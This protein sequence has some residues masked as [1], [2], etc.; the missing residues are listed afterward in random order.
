MPA[1][2]TDLCCKGNGAAKGMVPRQY[3]EPMTQQDSLVPAL[4]LFILWLERGIRESIAFCWIVS[5]I[6]LVSIHVAFWFS[7]VSAVSKDGPH[8]SF[9]SFALLMRWRSASADWTYVPATCW[10]HHLLSAFDFVDPDAVGAVAALP[11]TWWHKRCI[12]TQIIWRWLPLFCCCWFDNFSSYSLHPY[13]F[14]VFDFL[15]Q[16]W[17]FILLKKLKL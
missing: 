3:M 6:N 4:I 10:P 16:L 9:F 11:M 7:H 12:Y 17:L 15:Y 5:Y 13:M 8:A 14:V 1:C 2:Q